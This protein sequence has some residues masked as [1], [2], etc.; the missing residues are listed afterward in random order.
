MELKNKQ[1]NDALEPIKNK[2]IIM[3]E[4]NKEYKEAMDLN[5]SAILDSARFPPDEI[6][7][8]EREKKK[9]E[10]ENDKL[11]SELEELRAEQQSQSRILRSD[12][13]LRAAEVR[14]L[15][16]EKERVKD[17]YDKLKNESK[18]WDE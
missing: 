14:K 1:F 17:V 6:E 10:D 5:E 16:A 13:M 11:N 3:K 15:K 12:L 4:K 8:R 9:L 2:I 7:Q 18:L